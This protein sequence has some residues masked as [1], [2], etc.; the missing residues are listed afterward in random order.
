M[1][2]FQLAIEW[3]VGPL[4]CLVLYKCFVK[5]MVLKYGGL[6]DFSS[7]CLPAM[8]ANMHAHHCSLLKTGR[9]ATL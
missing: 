5:E 8:F 4:V 7:T 9:K 2:V 3:R 6:A 1:W